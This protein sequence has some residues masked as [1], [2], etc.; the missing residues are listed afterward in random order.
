[1][2]TS[3][4]ILGDLINIRGFVY[5]PVN[6]TGV[7]A[8]LAAMV[9]DLRLQ[10]EEVRPHAPHYIVRRQTRRV[11]E[12][13]AV[14]CAYKSSELQAQAWALEGSHLIVCWEHDWPDCPLDVIELPTVIHTPPLTPTRAHHLPG[15]GGYLARQPERTQRLFHRMDHGIRTLAP[16]IMAK[17]TKGRKRMGGVSY[18]APKRRFCCVDFLGTGHGLTLGMFTGGQPWE[19]VNRH[20]SAPWGS[21]PIQSDADLPRALGL[22]SAA[23]EAF[24]HAIQPQAPTRRRRRRGR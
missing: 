5:A 18:Y 12:R 16:D 19:G 15:L 7:I 11:W 10:V 1:M 17:T 22:V 20:V 2:S 23:Y 4:S 9:E 14:A 3:S 6:E 8:L 21:F 13:V 24:K